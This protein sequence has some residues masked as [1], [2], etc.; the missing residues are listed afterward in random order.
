MSRHMRS[1][2]FVFEARV[3][4]KKSEVRSVGR[5][6]W[7]VSLQMRSFPLLSWQHLRCFQSPLQ[8]SRVSTHIDISTLPV[9]F[10]ITPSRNGQKKSIP[11]CVR[12]SFPTPDRS[13][14]T[15]QIDNPTHH[16]RPLGLDPSWNFTIL[17]FSISSSLQRLPDRWKSRIQRPT[18]LLCS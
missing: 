14:N 10:E 16:C 5:E 17:C 7:L 1:W 12:R 15:S 6:G 18:S 2:N 4:S 8:R 11:K 3:R 13:S 9:L